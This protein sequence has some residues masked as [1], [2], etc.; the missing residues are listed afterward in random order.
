M[1]VDDDQDPLI[2]LETTEW[3]RTI[4][5]AIACVVAL[6][7]SR[8]VEFDG[9]PSGISEATGFIVDAKR[10]LIMTNRHVVGTGIFVGY[11][12]FDNHEECDVT[13]IYRDPVHDFGLLKF[14]PAKLKYL[15][16]QQLALRP[17]LAKVGTEIRIVGNDAGEKLSILS[18]YI[19]RRDR[20]PPDMG[21]AAYQDYNTEYIQ[22]SCNASGGSSGSPVIDIA[23]NVLG[24]ESAGGVYS[25]TDFFLPLFRPLRALKLLQKDLPITR[26]DVQVIWKKEPFEACRRADLA[27]ETE[28]KMRQAFP[29]SVG[30][31]SAVSIL[32]KG[33]CHKLVEAG[34]LLVS[35]NGEIVNSLVRVD[36]ILD[37]AV[38]KTVTLGLHRAGKDL[39]VDVVVA[40]LH[41]VTPSRLALIGQ[42]SFHEVGCQMAALRNCAIQGVFH[43]RESVV[44]LEVDGKPTPDLDA[45]VDA[46]RKCPSD[47]QVMAKACTLGSETSPFF[48]T[49][50]LTRTF[51]NRVTLYTRNDHSS[52]WDVKE[53][54]DEELSAAADSSVAASFADTG[55]PKVFDDFSHTF[56]S[57]HRVSKLPFYKHTNDNASE[58]S[59]IDAAKGYILVNSVNHG[60]GQHKFRF[61][62]SVEVDAHVVFEHPSLPFT[63]FQYD[64]KA[65]GDLPVKSLKFSTEKLKKGDKLTAVGFTYSGQFS[66]RDE[67]VAYFGTGANV[68]RVFFNTDNY[69]ARTEI[70]V[71][72]QG[73]TR[74][75]GLEAIDVVALADMLAML[76][77][78][79]LGEA[80]Y[81][82]LDLNSVEF[83][84]AQ[85]L[86]VPESWMA[87]VAA[88]AANRMFYIVRGKGND[89]L[90]ELE[91]NDVV[92]AV[93]G[94]LLTDTRQL[95]ALTTNAS[96]DLTV[97][98]TGGV[99][100]VTV[101]TVLATEYT[102]TPL[103]VSWC[104][105]Y[106]ESP[107]AFTKIRRT[108][109]TPSE[110]HISFIRAG[111]AL[112][113]YGVPHGAYI[114]HVNQTPVTTLQEFVAAVRQVPDATFVNLKL[115]DTSGIESRH[116]LK[117]D[118][119][120]FPTR[121]FVR[122]PK[123][124]NWRLQPAE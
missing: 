80:R 39:T 68:D 114:T 45:F 30:M 57:H 109:E 12:V 102:H 9:E 4:K 60:L 82:P 96:V 16:P 67:T 79:T 49:L 14:D 55:L 116:A 97:F 121:V 5:T 1:T 70:Y 93:N 27:T 59:V 23:G 108:R 24:I 48:T 69:N 7:Y 15:K 106:I 20:D 47:M 90:P 19:S 119:H 11:A 81:L 42:D 71:D 83:I 91:Y 105:A 73:L 64:P 35:I 18:G 34:D 26:G 123:T 56:A 115:R 50:N 66:T 29:A 10:G 99:H 84:Q 75:V 85:K 37:D 98:R 87:R 54:D 117:T 89:V 77:Q 22:A 52:R 41:A 6:H 65:L 53:F 101:H 51:G 62:D 124:V 118:Y 31:I 107:E 88:Q 104:G 72:A 58:G 78:G 8:P 122:E 61:A 120:Y 111:S 76:E 2:S 17:D 103:L 100:E 38:G 36:E 94:E 28:A 112:E 46:V 43:A 3:Q 33:P 86:G 63:I 25:S 32:P 95:M 13:P 74:A 44:I 92:L 110:A 113:F 21:Q 40:D